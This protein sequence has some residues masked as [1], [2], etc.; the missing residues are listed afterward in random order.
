MVAFSGDIFGKMLNVNIREQGSG[1]VGATNTLRALGTKFGFLALLGD[2]LKAVIASLLA[3]LIL[4]VIAGITSTPDEANIIILYAAFG[5]VIGHIYPAL[6]KFKGGKGVATCAGLLLAVSVGSLKTFL[7][8]FL[9]PAIIFF[10]I[11][12][13][14]KYISL[15]S[16]T[17]FTSAVIIM[18]IFNGD[19]ATKIVF[20]LLCLFVIYR[21]RENIQRLL[22]HKE[23]KVNFF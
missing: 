11:A 7:L 14:T 1:N 9:L 6:Y 20:T 22:N 2:C 13:I 4:V 15:A 23:N 18:W 12:V 21:H 17:A 16:M 19:L 8:Q 10:A 3:Y 5:A